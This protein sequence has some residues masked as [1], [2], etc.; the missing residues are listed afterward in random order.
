VAGVEGTL[1]DR[2]RRSPAEGVLRA[3]TGTLGGVYNLAGYVP[4]GETQ[5]PFVMMSRTSPN[6]GS[7]VRPS[8]DRVGLELARVHAT[9]AT[10]V[11]WPSP[12][13]L[14]PFVKEHSGESRR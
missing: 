3:K 6:R 1:R 5:I 4:Y 10:T 7:V 12:K 8:L 11:D 9:Q 13:P 2:M 14:I